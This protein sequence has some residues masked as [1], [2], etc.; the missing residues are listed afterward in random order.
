MFRS[1]IKRGYFGH[2]RSRIPVPIGDRGEE[3]EEWHV[4]KLDHGKEPGVLIKR[5]SERVGVGVAKIGE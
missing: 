1:R 3:G 2:A 4:G 5:I